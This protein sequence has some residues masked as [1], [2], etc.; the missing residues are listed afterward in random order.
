LLLVGGLSLY[1]QQ[2]IP[3]PDVYLLSAVAVILVASSLSL[4]GKGLGYFLF[5]PVAILSALSLVFLFRIDPGS[6]G[7]NLRP[8]G[9]NISG[10]FFLSLWPGVCAYY[11]NGLADASIGQGK[12]LVTPL[13]MAMV[14]GAIGDGGMM[15]QPYLVQE[16]RDPNGGYSLL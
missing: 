16:I 12:I 7:R 9:R 6:A 5:L 2:L 14:A 3:R 13:Y 1:R 8:A 15:M 11:L 10:W 4:Q